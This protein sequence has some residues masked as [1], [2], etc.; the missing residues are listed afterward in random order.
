[1]TEVLAWVRGKIAKCIELRE[2]QQVIKIGKL[3]YEN[4]SA[5]PTQASRSRVVSTVRPGAR[6]VTC[7]PSLEQSGPRS[8]SFLTIVTG[9]THPRARATER[10]AGMWKQTRTMASSL[11]LFGLP[12]A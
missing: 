1:M 5:P 9:R 8:A 12:S 11:R 3:T 4:D 7:E 2:P 10:A 6:P